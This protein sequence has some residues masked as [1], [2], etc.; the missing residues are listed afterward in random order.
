MTKFPLIYSKL[1]IP[2]LPKKSLFT[3]RMQKL[4]IEKNKISILSA[5]AGFGKTTAV[6]L[7]LQKHRKNTC[8]YRLE[9]ED[10]FLPMFYTHLIE[11]LFGGEKGAEAESFSLLESIQNIEEDY[12]LMNA[13]IAED[14]TLIYGAREN[15]QKIYLVLDDFHN[16]QDNQK[17]IEIMQYFFTN[18]PDYFSF[19]FTTRRMPNL[20]NA[21]LALREDVRIIGN[22]D[23]S[24]RKNEI[25]ELVKSKYKLDL[26]PRQ[27]EY[28]TAHS[29]GWIA[30]I[31]MICQGFR[32]VM[33]E[34][35]ELFQIKTGAAIF[36]IFLSEFMESLETDKR[37]ILIYLSQLEDFSAEELSQ[38]FGLQEADAFIKWMES[39]NL[40][41]QK[42]ADSPV[43]CRFHSLFREELE[44][45]FFKTIDL[46]AQKKIFADLARFYRERDSAKS[47]RYLLKAGLKKD[48]YQ[49]V[50]EKGEEYFVKGM[51]EQ[52][53][54]LLQEFNQEEIEEEPYLLLFC[55]MLSINTDR[56]S[57]YRLLIKAMKGFR[58]RGNYSF[59]MNT[60]GMML[61]FAYQNNNFS[62]LEEASKE[63]RFL[64]IFF[65]SKEVR[66]KLIIS[67]FISLTGRDLL[68]F[69]APLCR[70]LDRLEIKEDM[71]NY[72]YYMISGLY[73]YRRGN[74]LRSK[75][76]LEKILS[77]PVGK[78]NAQ[79]RIIGLV[80]CCNLPILTA[81]KALLTDFMNEF[82]LLG[83]RFNSDF[84][85]GYGYFISAHRQY[86]ENDVKG[87]LKSI[88]SSVESY[89]NYG[90]E[91][92][93]RESELIRILWDEEA[94]PSQ[95]QKELEEHL[96]FFGAQEPGNGLL[97]FT[98]CLKG[99]L[100]KRRRDYQNAEA[101]LLQAF[102]M[103][104][105]KK[106]VQDAC[107]ACLH[108]ADLYLLMQN[109]ARAS[110]FM[111][112]WLGLSR[113]HS[114]V[115][116]RQMDRES[117]NR[118]CAA[119]EL[120]PEH[121]E[122]IKDIESRYLAKALS[123]PETKSGVRI[124][125]FGKFKI[126]F[127]DIIISEEQFKTKKARAVLQYILS[128][129][130]KSPVS[131]EKLA[132]IFWP[133]SESKAAYASLRVALYQIRKAFS[134]SGLDFEGENSLLK[135]DRCGIA[136][137]DSLLIQSD[138]EEFEKSF[139]EWKS[140]DPNAKDPRI[141][142]EMLAMYQ[143]DYLENSCFEDSMLM[144]QNYYLSLFL[145]ASH[146]LGKMLSDMFCFAEAEEVL[147]K[148]L[149]KDPFDETACTL[150]VDLC[151]KQNQNDRGQDLK[152]RFIRRYKKEMG[153]EPFTGTG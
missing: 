79:W 78:L 24:F 105:Q 2:D 129:N 115:F 19:V 110:E 9:K 7:S 77:H 150:L 127:G 86:I 106:S 91:L 84:S 72:S 44:S 145:E 42:I 11:C 31:Y 38:V 22:E 118:I 137:S 37:R 18:F 124:D 82:F 88:V 74:L 93:A 47:I 103:A 28:L 125:F 17:I 149:E 113:K 41:I 33:Q 151:M 111:E 10:A 148:A 50:K 80:S 95:S 46:E 104:I 126:S 40:Y 122:F 62:H 90:G 23:L 107:G 143:G 101:F 1:M 66:I 70:L 83:E 39:S 136:I 138:A 3:E 54:F 109:E 139:T 140:G 20:I 134:E 43:R 15:A 21:K 130:K 45:I 135:E 69:A 16:I 59:L 144:K 12:L 131:R 53:F 6:L 99:I 108:L 52:M 123:K 36:S 152:K 146:A 25:K 96:Q 119:K 65:S 14:V 153:Y 133:N 81:D 147:L 30:G 34:N 51:P 5:P 117:L 100:Y 89:R 4:A 94:D 114:Y 60:F 68:R 92:L 73:Q 35:E 8:W 76:I 27:M 67:I 75:D 120:Y 13:Q 128:G 64:P 112:K 142:R 57:S 132:A 71:W 26:T 56:A 87:A 58:K 116:W 102:K 29:E 32:L 97:D 85:T 61:V 48:A 63:I 141:L 98:T 121:L 55:G 49:I